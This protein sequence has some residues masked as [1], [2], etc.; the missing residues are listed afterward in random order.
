MAPI[1]LTRRTLATAAACVPLFVGLVNYA[2]STLVGVAW[3]PTERLPW[4]AF[5]QPFSFAEAAR[6]APDLADLLAVH[7]GPAALGPHLVGVVSVTAVIPGLERS[8]KW[9]WLSLMSV[10]VLGGLGDTAA[11]MRHALRKVHSGQSTTV[12]GAITG[13]LWSLFPLLATLG[14]AATLWVYRECSAAPL[15]PATDTALAASAPRP[16]RRWAQTWMATTTLTASTAVLY[17]WGASFQRSF[18]MSPDHPI[19]IAGT[20]FPMSADAVMDRASETAVDMGEPPAGAVVQSAASLLLM[21]AQVAWSAGPLA[22]VLP[23]FLAAL[24][25]NDPSRRLRRRSLQ[26]LVYVALVLLF[27]AAVVQRRWVALAMPMTTAGAQL[28]ATAVTLNTGYALMLL[29]GSGV[30]WLLAARHDNH[31]KSAAEAPHGAH[32]KQS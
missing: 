27:D 6:E 2:S 11:F 31:G 23:A 15:A 10:I 3:A 25:V 22:A 32:S 5:P 14:G 12:L 8:R 26:A 29:A 20:V 17:H 1:R 9:A 13:D 7:L 21:A 16:P 30:H 18:T 4:I 24:G 19:T 28:H